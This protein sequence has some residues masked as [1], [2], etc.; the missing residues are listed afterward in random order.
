MCQAQES[1]S[2]Q[3]ARLD[4]LPSENNDPE[5]TL[6]SLITMGFPI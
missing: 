1:H 3:A 6:V 4:I 2:P 5:R